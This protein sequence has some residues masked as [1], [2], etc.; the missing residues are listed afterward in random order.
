MSVKFGLMPIHREVV[1]DSW[2]S[3]HSKL[4]NLSGLT[5][6]W[7]HNR[8]RQVPPLCIYTGNDRK[9]LGIFQQRKSTLSVAHLDIW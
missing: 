5:S 4:P 3:A 1:N 7:A 2:M 6:R 8:P 9:C